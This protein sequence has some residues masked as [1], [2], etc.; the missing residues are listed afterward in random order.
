MEDVMSVQFCLNVL[1]LVMI[2]MF[3]IHFVGRATPFRSFLA[4]VVIYIGIV[5]FAACN[6]PSVF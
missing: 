3:P 5:I 2:L 4:A 6:V 1:V